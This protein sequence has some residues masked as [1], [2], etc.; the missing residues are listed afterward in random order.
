MAQGQEGVAE[1]SG[2]TVKTADAALGQKRPSRK[3]CHG[4][5]IRVVAALARWARIAL[6]AAPGGLARRLCA[7]RTNQKWRRYTPHGNRIDSELSHAAL[8][9]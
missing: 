2:T 3:G 4:A 1:R 8:A 5:A 6:R 7:L 9:A